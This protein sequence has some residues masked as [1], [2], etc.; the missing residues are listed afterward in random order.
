[1][2]GPDHNC[3]VAGCSGATIAALLRTQ[4]PA[5]GKAACF[6]QRIW[7]HSFCLLSADALGSALLVAAATATASKQCCLSARAP[8]LAT[9]KKARS[10]EI[11]TSS[12]SAH[13][14]EVVELAEHVLASSATLRPE[15]LAQLPHAPRHGEQH[16]RVSLVDAL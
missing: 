11:R 7:L 3:G 6:S 16:G 10:F 8:P 9:P 2:P 1:M 4:R 14:F 12:F 5:D 15:R 13:P